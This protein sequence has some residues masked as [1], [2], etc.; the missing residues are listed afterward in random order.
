[1]LL[2]NEIDCPPRE[3]AAE[4][5][6]AA[7]HTPQPE[8]RRRIEDEMAF[9]RRAARRWQRQPADADDLVQDTLLRALANAHLWQPGT[10]LR[11]WLYTIMRNCFLAGVARSVRSTA[12]LEQI[13]AVDP[14]PGAP[15]SELRLLLRD[16]AAALRRLPASQR[17][18]V[19]LIGLEGKSY[20][21]AA[22]TMGTSVGAVRSHLARGRDRLRTAVHG[23]DNRF[24]FAPRPS[25]APLA[26]AGGD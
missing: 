14:G 8:F 22:Q 15:E 6:P 4:T 23:S 16:L 7:G 26:A 10:D 18:A 3:A 25:A 17:S 11:A 2:S 20:H 13:A 19:I 12:R 5:P 24:P 9:L 21:E 1:M